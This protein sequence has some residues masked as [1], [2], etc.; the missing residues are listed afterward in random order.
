MTWSKN[1]DVRGAAA[2]LGWTMVAAMLIVLLPAGGRPAAAQEKE[3]FV[4]EID[5]NDGSR[6]DLRLTGLDR[7]DESFSVC[8][9]NFDV[10]ACTADLN[11]IEAIVDRIDIRCAKGPRHGTPPNASQDYLWKG[12]FSQLKKLIRRACKVIMKI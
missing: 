1:M 5:C 6:I 7:G 9:R 8:D 4:L 10:T 11:S 3:L 2:R 12:E